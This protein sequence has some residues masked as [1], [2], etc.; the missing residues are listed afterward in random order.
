M[1]C[2]IW[3]G[4]GL[5]VVSTGCSSG[6]NA[7]SP[8]SEA[9]LSLTD[10]A[11]GSYVNAS[12]ITAVSFGGSCRTDGDVTLTL[13]DS[14]AAQTTVT[15]A[16]AG[17]A[18]RTAA[19]D[20]TGRAS[21][22]LSVIAT[23]TVGG[24]SATSATLALTIDILPP[25]LTA[26]VFPTTPAQTLTAFTLTGVDVA[27]YRYKFGPA[28]SLDCTDLTGYGVATPVSTPVAPTLTSIVDGSVKGCFIAA[29]VAGNWIAAAN[30]ISATFVK[31]TTVTALTSLSLV[32]SG[33]SNNGQPA[34][35]G[36]TEVAYGGLIANQTNVALFGGATCA[37]T[38]LGTVPADVGGNFSL[39][40]A[41]ALPADGSFTFSVR[42]TDVAG[43]TLCAL[44]PGTLI[45]DRVAPALVV[46]T[47][48]AAATLGATVTSTGTCETG[49]NVVFAGTDITP[50]S[51]ACAAAT[52]SQV[53][54]FGPGEGAKTFTI[55]QTDAAGNA[56]V[57]TRTVTKD[58]VAPALSLYSPP[59]SASFQSTFTVAGGCETGAGVVS[60]AGGVSAAG[61]LACTAGTFS[62]PITLAAPDGAKAVLFSQSDA[63]GNVGSV[64]LNLLRDNVPPVLTILE[65]AAGWVAQGEVTVAGTCESGWPITVDGTGVI[66]GAPAT[67]V[68]NTFLIPVVLTA[69]ASVK[70]LQFSQT[71]AA[72]NVGSVTRTVTTIV[73]PGTALT[74]SPPTLIS[75]STVTL[76]DSTSTTPIYLDNLTDYNLVCD[77]AANGHIS[78][79][80]IDVRG[81]RNV[82]M[83]GCNVQRTLA[84]PAA[85]Y[86][87]SDPGTNLNCP[88]IA[89]PHALIRLSGQVGVAYLEGVVA[90]LQNSISDQNNYGVSGIDV[91][92][93]YAYATV[94]LSGSI[95]AGDVINLTFSNPVAVAK[96]LL[97]GLP[98]S[99]HYAVNAGDTLTSMATQFTNLINSDPNLSALGITASQTSNAGNPH[100]FTISHQMPS[101]GTTQ[102][103]ASMNSG[104]SETLTL[105]PASGILNP[106]S[107]VLQNVRVEN[108]WGT[109]CGIASAALQLRGHLN[110]LYLDHVTLTGASTLFLAQPSFEVRDA[111]VYNFTSL[112]LDTDYSHQMADGTGFSVGAN[113]YSWW[114]G[115]GNLNSDCPTCHFNV[116]M[117]NA[118]AD[119]R[120]N[121]GS[122]WQIS[123]I[124][125]PRGSTYGNYD[126]TTS[127]QSVSFTA[128]PGTSISGALGIYSVVTGDLTPRTTIVDGA[129]NVTYAPVGAFSN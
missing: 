18:F 103:S 96:N 102:V 62:G 99:V 53:V 105:N 107:Y 91:G 123:S 2:R 128:Q 8:S 94:L 9:A 67:C 81:G 29:D 100:A 24:R 89:N 32:P 73:P 124:S 90:N 79:T 127:P 23:G 86:P 26:P 36:S 20:L 40:P 121:F 101:G 111:Q 74:W 21:G 13:T 17:G 52:F 30:A 108:A 38:A 22:T 60:Y 71:D 7:K 39:T 95:G 82:V 44:V 43:N 1:R 117:Q 14:A 88:T 12:L 47:P 25:T 27:S 70:Q 68:A 49:L 64:T 15:A 19:Q 106:V 33:A 3:I 113:G 48:V 66:T 31:D 16:C 83:K 87:P 45:L 72:G 78:R 50:V 37:G 125:P 85:A 10:P 35:A 58:T 46:S 110:K 63:A 119:S 54:A 28:A 84:T 57:V 55:T 76:T 41:L 115:D 65:P 126:V 6:F 4:L 42:A 104:A 116:N 77:P 92:E 114:L 120:L 51:V 61:T 11:A 122:P 59:G 98:Y 34:I 97:T 109:S 118:F 56:T 5:A 129:G 69:G 112:Y 93:N 80:T 75:P